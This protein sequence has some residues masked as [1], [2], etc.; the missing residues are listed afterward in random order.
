MKSRILLA[1]VFVCLAFISCDNTPSTGL[2]ALVT[3]SLSDFADDGKYGYGKEFPNAST[4]EITDEVEL[5]SSEELDGLLDQV[6]NFQSEHNL[7]VSLVF[8]KAYAVGNAAFMNS[9]VKYV[10][11]PEVVTIYPFAF[12]GCESLEILV[13]SSDGELVVSAQ[14]FLD[15][16]TDNTV[17]WLN[18]NK[19][20]VDID[21]LTDGTYTWKE[22]KYD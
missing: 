3:C 16:S 11:M 22:L 5:T 1:L 6:S 21:Y 18:E 9:E 19:E 10:F 15:A 13:L 12:Q 14:A 4:W 7:P 20:D 2:D 17:L 8:D